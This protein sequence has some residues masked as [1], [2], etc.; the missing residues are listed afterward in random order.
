LSLCHEGA[1]LNLEHES[2]LVTGGSGTFGRGFVREAL[3]QGAVRVCI[4]SR[5]EYQ[6]HLMREWF[7]DDYRLRW[8]IGDVRDKDR[9]RRAMQGVDVV[10]HA[11]ALKRIETAHYNPDEVIK[12]NVSGTMNML[13]GAEASGVRKVVLVSTDKAANPKSVYGL[14]KATA[15][16]LVIAANNMRSAKGPTYSV[17]RFGNVW[18]STGSIVPRWRA[19]IAAGA[20]A[21]PV[22]DPECTRFFMRLEEAAALVYREAMLPDGGRTVI[23]GLPAY[24]VSDLAEAMGVEIRVTGLPQFEKEHETMDGITHSNEVRRMSV[25]ELRAELLRG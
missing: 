25:D 5:G 19:L 22:T 18:C 3:N 15:E 12:T 8:M 16:S 24:R 13:E 2:I 6:Q 14:S 7:C 9:L 4:F 1:W 11:A 23:P 21:V 10:I 17:C 20:K